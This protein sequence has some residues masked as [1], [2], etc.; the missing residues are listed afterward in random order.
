MSLAVIL[1]A[2]GCLVA[3]TFLWQRNKTA[4]IDGAGRGWT[5]VAITVLVLAGVMLALASQTIFRG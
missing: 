4:G 5:R 2:L 1:L 3:A